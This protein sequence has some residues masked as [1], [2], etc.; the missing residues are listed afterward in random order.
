MDSIDDAPAKPAAATETEPPM[1][2]AARN[3]R[4]ERLDITSSIA[5]S[6]KNP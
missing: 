5:E 2:R 6:L 1:M 4:M 3:E